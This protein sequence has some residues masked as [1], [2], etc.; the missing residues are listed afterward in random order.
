MVHLLQQVWTYHLTTKSNDARAW[1][2]EIAEAASRKH[3]TTSIVPGGG[4]YGRIWKLTPA[5]VEF[6]FANSHML[7]DEEVRYA[8]AH[9]N[10]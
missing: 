1:A 5:G 9:C 10:R 6:L 3:I 7:S 8:E 2:D 4:V